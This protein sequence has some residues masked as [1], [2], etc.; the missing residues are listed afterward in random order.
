MKIALVGIYYPL[1]ML[2]YFENALKRRDDIELVTVGPYTGMWIPWNGGMNVAAKYDK[3]PDFPLPQRAI[4]M[5]RINP[6]VFQSSPEFADVDLWLEI[7]AGFYLYPRPTTGIVAHVATDPHCLNYTEQRK[8]ADHFFC[9]Q[10]PYMEQGDRYLPYAHDR[11]IHYHMNI[12][13]EYDACLIGLMYE[14]RWQLI[15]RLRE[16]GLEVHHGLGPIF[17][18]YRELCNKSKI[19]LNWSSLLDTNARCFEL[20]A[21]GVPAVMNRTPDLNKFLTDGIDYLGFDTLDEAVK[22]TLTLYEDED[23]RKELAWNAKMAI[24]PH[25]YDA[26]IQEILDVC[27]I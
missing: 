12:E 1:A 13:K 14:H 16:Q 2:R 10:T 24:A 18:E 5:G 8:L 3:A 25:T 6:Q 27:G 9:M 19:G 20:A 22:Q 11:E 23:L 7:D 26:R 17:D 21:M 4:G 15:Q